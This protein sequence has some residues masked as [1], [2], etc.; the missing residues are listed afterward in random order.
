MNVKQELNKLR[1]ALNEHNHRYYVLDEPTISDAE[2][3]QLFRKLK[4]LEDKH[5]ELITPDSPTQRIGAEPLKAFAK[6]IHDIPMLSLDNAFSEEEL[7]AFDKRV[8]DRLKTEDD[9]QYCCEPKLDGV[10]VT[11]RYEHGYLTRAGTR[12]D[13][14]VGEDITEN[15][16]T[17]QMIPLKLRGQNH[18]PSIDVRGE[19]FISKKGFLELNEKA[20]ADKLKIFVNARNAAAGSL[21]QLDSRITAERPLEIFFYGVATSSQEN[22]ADTQFKVLSQLSAWGLRVNPLIKV[23]NSV[24]GCEKYYREMAQKRHFLPYEIDGIVFKVNSLLLQEKL[25]FVSRAPRFAIAQKF[26]AE[27]VSTVIQ[28]VDFQVGRTG[29]VTPV[30]RL[31]PVF[32]HGVTVSN[33]T[34]HNMDEVERKD[35]HIGDTVIIRRAGDVIPE[36]VSVVLELRKHVKKIHLP[37][38]CPVCHSEIEHIPGEAVA[39]CTGGLFCPAQRKEAIKHFSARRMM[40]IEGLGDKLVEQ[41]VDC[42]LLQNVSDIYHL[43]QHDLEKLERMEKSLLKIS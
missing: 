33:A 6:V 40:D 8:K 9:I 21:R 3:D 12:G 19:V 24:M 22:I 10:A 4:L 32:V 34:L 36:V 37:K 5:P 16:K 39:R 43:K 11:L 29:A 26:P 7:I 42:E 17:I 14:S 1:D 23:V 28:S 30:A 18:P 15:I 35:V 20:H 31:L 41:L 2:Y 27:E 25:G 13:G 38:H